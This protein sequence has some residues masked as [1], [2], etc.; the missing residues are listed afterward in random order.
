MHHFQFSL[1]L[2]L[3]ACANGDPYEPDS[4]LGANCTITVDETWPTQGA[5]DFYF[6]DSIEFR[7][8]EPDPDARVVFGRS[9]TQSTAE[10]G[11]MVVFTPDQPLPS[12][13]D[14][15]V[16]L[17]Y[18]FGSPKIGFSTSNLGEPI[19]DIQALQGTTYRV[20]LQD[21]RY[22][23][24]AGAADFLMGWLGRSLLFQVIEY[25]NNEITLRMAVSKA[26]DTSEQ[27]LCY[28]TF[29][30][31]GMQLE[32]SE[33]VLDFDDILFEFYNG[34]LEV[35]DFTLLGTLAP[36]LSHVGGAEFTGWLNITDFTDSLELGED[37]D[38]CEIID[39]LD[40]SCEPCPDN[41]SQSCIHLMG[42]RLTALAVDTELEIIEERDSHPECELSQKEE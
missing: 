7:L 38:L 13:T 34:S 15:E 14:F 29:D 19:E 36:D 21:A 12:S 2:L 30:I 5:D 41:E 1:C 39:N 17:E 35:G 10:D 3:L 33:L 4:T 42:D 11:H 20:D 32:G 18:C 23:E 37:E 16:G 28:R 6:R 22:L 24:N 40:S 26:G 8:S 25:Q 9:G 27:D 31:D